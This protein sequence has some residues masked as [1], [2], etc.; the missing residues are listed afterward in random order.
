MLEQ[1]VRRDWVGKDKGTLL[2]LPDWIP[3]DARAHPR[4]YLVPQPTTEPE[5]ESDDG[6]NDGSD[7]ESIEWEEMTGKG[8]D[9]TK[10]DTVDE[11][12]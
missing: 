8:G 9:M 12:F 5:N 4:S 3:A 6:S 2:A 10:F 1:Y 7:A 11:D